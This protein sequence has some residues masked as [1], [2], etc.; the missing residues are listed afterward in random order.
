M[1]Y[2]RRL[3]VSTVGRYLHMCRYSRGPQ[4]G[5]VTRAAAADD[6]DVFDPDY[7]PDD[8]DE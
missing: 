2:I 8:D 4:Q 1:V 5:T 6:D 7:V 3:Y